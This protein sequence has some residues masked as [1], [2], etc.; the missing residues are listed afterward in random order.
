MDIA[1]RAGAEESQDGS[2]TADDQGEGGEFR[3]RFDRKFSVPPV[4]VESLARR[5]GREQLCRSVLDALPPAI[6]TTDAAGRITYYNR[7]A[8]DLAGR[9]PELGKDEWCVT[10]RLYRLDGTPMAH[11]HRGG[12]RRDRRDQRG[13]GA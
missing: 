13:S 6:Y 10:W 12:A 7:A 1:D 8:A 2:V 3:R 4:P 11:D 9:C 5:T